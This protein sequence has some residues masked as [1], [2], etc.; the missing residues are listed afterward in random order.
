MNYWVCFIGPVERNK[1]PNGGDFPLR[2][3]VK[4]AFFN[5]FGKSPNVCSSG[6]GYNEEF[7][8]LVSKLSIME[9]ANHPDYERLKS[10]ILNIEI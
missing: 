6:W 9:T 7:M 3:S 2:S 1:I 10:E 5:T 8:D 4:E